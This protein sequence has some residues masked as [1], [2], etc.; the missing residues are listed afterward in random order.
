MATVYHNTTHIEGEELQ[1]RINSAEGQL[2]EFKE[3]F[4]I[5]PN[6]TKWEARRRYV[7]HYGPIDEIQPGARIDALVDKGIIYK[8]TEKWLEERG[9][10]NYV[11]KMYPTDGSV[12]EDYNNKVPKISIPLQFNE[13]GTLN[14]DQTLNIFLDKYSKQEKKYN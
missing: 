7:E 5:Y 6:M 3:L 12:P 9:A 8:S 14:F 1:Q 2:E 11:Y 10:K 4:K 13:D